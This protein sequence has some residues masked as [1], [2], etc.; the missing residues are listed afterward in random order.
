MR[1]RTA[2][3]EVGEKSPQPLENAFPAQVAESD[4]F[5]QDRKNHIGSRPY[6]LGLRNQYRLPDGFEVAAPAAQVGELSKRLPSET[7]PHPFWETAGRG[8]L[9]FLLEA[10]RPVPLPEHV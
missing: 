7:L 3:L 5:L 9:A 2:H 6:G 1:H 4:F 10:L 8:E